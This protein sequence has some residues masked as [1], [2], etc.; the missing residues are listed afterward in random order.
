MTLVALQFF[1]GRCSPVFSARSFFSSRWRQR[2]ASCRS[3][4][5][6]GRRA[7]DVS[8]ASCGH[9]ARGG[10]RIARPGSSSLDEPHTLTARNLASPLPPGGPLVLFLTAGSRLRTRGSGFPGLSAVEGSRTRSIGV[11]EVV[12]GVVLVALV[13]ALATGHH[14]TEPRVCVAADDGAD[15]GRASAHS[16]CRITCWLSSCRSRAITTRLSCTCAR[17]CEAEIRARGTCSASSFFNAGKLLEAVDTV[18]RVRADLGGSFSSRD[19]LNPP[20]EPG[21]SSWHT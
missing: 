20:H 19:G 8:P 13:G 10:S 14:P 5:G 4:R 12:A 1:A 15:G 11:G 7:A 3:R 16:A 18:R 2:R 9:R 17:P 21:R 6:S